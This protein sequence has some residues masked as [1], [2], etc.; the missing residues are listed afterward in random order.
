MSN[1]LQ[2]WAVISPLSLALLCQSIYAPQPAPGFLHSWNNC[3]T[4]AAHAQ[5][6]GADVI[7]FRGSLTALDWTLDVAAV[8]IDDPQ[9]GFVHGGFMVGVRDTLIAASNDVPGLHRNLVVCGHSLGGARARLFAGLCIANGIPVS[10]CTVFG[11]PRPAFYLRRLFQKAG[12]AA[13]SYRNRR[14]LVPMVPFPLPDFPWDHTDDYI[15]LDAPA[16]GDDF[17]RLRDHPSA[18]YIAGLQ[19]L[20]AA[21]LPLPVAA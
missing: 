2:G 3:G 11:S 6:D 18:L 14:D 9:L 20:E 7:V 8:P 1:S 19:K 13:T 10:Q 21:N 4:V 16:A 5:I 15:A 12:L 17:D